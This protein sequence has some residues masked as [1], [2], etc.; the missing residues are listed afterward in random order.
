MK[1]I[2]IVIL[3]IATEMILIYSTVRMAREVIDWLSYPK[4]YKWWGFWRDVID[5]VILVAFSV[6]EFL[7]I[8]NHIQ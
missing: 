8:L 5:M 3:M 7:L 6:I 1:E 4:S 2:I